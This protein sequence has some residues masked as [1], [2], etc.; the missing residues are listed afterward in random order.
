MKAKDA[1]GILLSL[2]AVLSCDR[3]QMTFTD[4]SF[5]FS[6]KESV[7]AESL[8]TMV[9]LSLEKGAASIPYSVAYLID[10]NASLAMSDL[11]GN[12]VPTKATV[13]FEDFPSVTWMLPILEE[14][15]HKLAF[16]IRSESYSQ[17]LD[18]P[19]EVSISPFAIHAE[20][21]SPSSSKVSSL[22]INLTQGIAD[23]EYKGRVLIDGTCIDDRGFSVNFSNTPILVLEI[24]DVRPGSHDILIEL[25]DGKRPE[26]FSLRFDEPLRH[27]NLDLYIT[28]DSQSG[29]SRL[30]VHDNPYDLSLEVTDSL[31][32]TGCCQYSMPGSPDCYTRQTS[33]NSAKGSSFLERFIPEDGV[34]YDLIDRKSI[35]KRVT[36][37]GV[38]TKVWD[39]VWRTDSEG[40]WDYYEIDGPFVHYQI[41]SSKLYIHADFEKMQ[42]VTVHVHCTESGCIFNGKAIEENTEYTYQL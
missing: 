26:T 37:D 9:T 31:I 14:G 20:V 16:K 2:V 41:T 8:Q 4:N 7:N 12:P 36:D 28:H 33:Y 1:F 10:G 38:Q 11:E 17:E 19:F 30:L 23:R 22:M 3:Q 29:Y 24:P 5:V 13:S 18:L 25:S 32:V 34:Y 39:K 35:E 21:S 42:G 15:S 6:A 27:P 40:Y